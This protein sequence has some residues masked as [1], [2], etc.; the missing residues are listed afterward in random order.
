M[1]ACKGFSRLKTCFDN[2]LKIL[3]WKFKFESSDFEYLDD[4][5]SN[6]ENDFFF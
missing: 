1:V 5:T 4:F 6:L 2:M 3:K